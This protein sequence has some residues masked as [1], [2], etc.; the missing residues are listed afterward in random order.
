MPSIHVY[1]H[2]GRSVDQKRGL[3]E[4]ITAAIV[5]N[6]GAL[7]EATEVVIHDVPK[8]NW[9]TAGKLASDA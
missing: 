6:T 1:M 8:T 5:K 3:A 4:D 9:S 2:E 7:A